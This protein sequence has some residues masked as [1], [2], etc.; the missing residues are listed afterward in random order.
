MTAASTYICCFCFF[1]IQS[2]STAKSMAKSVYFNGI[3]FWPQQNT[4][5]NRPQ[6]FFLLFFF[7]CQWLAVDL[8][9]KK[10]PFQNIMLGGKLPKR[11][12]RSKKEEESWKKNKQKGSAEFCVIFTRTIK[13]L[14]LSTGALRRSLF[15]WANPC[16]VLSSPAQ[17][18]QS[19]KCPCQKAVTQHSVGESTVLI[20]INPAAG[21]WGK[22]IQLLLSQKILWLFFQ[23]RKTLE[24]LAY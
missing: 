18:P 12:S 20:N 1:N 3:R 19:S 10:K 16:P 7:F 9:Q 17:D 15:C 14:L 21:V 8:F 23:R 13:S 22:N 2:S 4:E 6:L 24:V 11:S 5:R